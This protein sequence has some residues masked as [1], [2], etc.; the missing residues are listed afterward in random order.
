MFTVLINSHQSPNAAYLFLWEHK[1]T[2]MEIPIVKM[3]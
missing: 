3:I 2:L 1:S